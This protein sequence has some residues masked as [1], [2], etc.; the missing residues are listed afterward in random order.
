MALRGL[1]SQTARCVFIK[2]PRKQGVATRAYILV[3]AKAGRAP[4]LARTLR[5]VPGVES[6]DLVTG[7]CDLIGVIDASNLGAVA[8]LVTKQLRVT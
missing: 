1:V 8:D 5:C 7:S 6:T 3:Q 4:C 2:S